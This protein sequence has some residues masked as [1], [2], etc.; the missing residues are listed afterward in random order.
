MRVHSRWREQQWR[1]RHTAKLRH[2]GRGG[3]E[4][5]DGQMEGRGAHRRKMI[6]KP[7]IHCSLMILCS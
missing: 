5:G 6:N 7:E 1:I 2:N 4:E 3:D